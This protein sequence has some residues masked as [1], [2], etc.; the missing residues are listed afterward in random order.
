MT[1]ALVWDTLIV[2]CG[3]IGGWLLCKAWYTPGL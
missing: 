2:T 3:A 1:L